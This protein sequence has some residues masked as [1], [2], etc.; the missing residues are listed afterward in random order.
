MQGAWY[1]QQQVQQLTH[2]QEAANRRTRE[3]E[4]ENHALHRQVSSFMS[5]VVSV[6][7][8][9]SFFLT[10]QQVRQLEEEKAHSQQMADRAQQRTREEGEN[11]GLQQ[12]VS[13]HDHCYVD[14]V[15]IEQFHAA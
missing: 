7:F 8:T 13:L 14:S 10:H 5:D 1:D 4:E 12:L 15:T 3:M 6:S 2:E 9:T 11:H